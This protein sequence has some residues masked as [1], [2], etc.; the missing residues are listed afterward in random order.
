LVEAREQVRIVLG[1]FARERLARDVD[2]IGIDL[3]PDLARD[4]R[5]GGQGQR[6]GAERRFEAPVA[7]D[8]GGG[9]DQTLAELNGLL[10]ANRSKALYERLGEDGVQSLP[11]RHEIAVLAGEEQQVVRALLDR[12]GDRC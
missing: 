8:L 7:G 9:A 12:Q 10:A 5:L 2:R 6:E 11:A 1:Y 3:R 4:V